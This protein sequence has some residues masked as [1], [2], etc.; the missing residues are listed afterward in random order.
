MSCILHIETSTNVCSVAV[1]D[2]GEVIF[3]EEDHSGPNH[4]EKL[5]VFVDEALS[6]IDN[7][8]IPLKA[9]AV[10][11]GPGSYTG[12][13]IGVSMAKGICYGRSVKLIAVPTLELLS[14]PVLLREEIKE[15]NALLCPMLDARRMEVYAG[16]YD[17]ALKPKREIQADIVD[18]NTYKTFLDKGKVYF[19]GNGA[20][21]CMEAIAHPNAVLIEGIEPL[22]KY[23]QPLAERRFAE[24][25]FEDVAYFVPFYLKD[26]V[27]IKPKKLL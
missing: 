4:A 15:D 1:S 23:M 5:G 17:R 11:C 9:V 26:F 13:R 3:N 27:A 22:A 7:H 16:L 20:A 14:V 24:E 12:L 19:F 6:F 10:S 18:A 25:V 21:K 2:G 8:A